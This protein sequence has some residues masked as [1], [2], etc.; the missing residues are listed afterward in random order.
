MQGDVLYDAVALVEDAED[1]DALSHRRDTALSVR[2]RGDL[3]SRRSSR[4]LLL[5]A[6]AARAERE[7]N[8]QRCGKPLHAYSGIH[9]S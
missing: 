3:R 1:G 9:G 8:Q 6:L 5:R 4:I 7:G 2:R